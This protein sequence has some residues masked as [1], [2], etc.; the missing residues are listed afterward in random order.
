MFELIH[1]SR[2]VVF[3]CARFYYLIGH[4][5]NAQ[6]SSIFASKLARFLQGAHPY[7]EAYRQKFYIAH[8][9]HYDYLYEMG[10]L[11]RSP[12]T[13]VVVLNAAKL[14]DTRPLSRN[15][16]TDAAINAYKTA[17]DRFEMFGDKTAYYIKSRILELH[18][19]MDNIDFDE[20]IINIKKYEN[21]VSSSLLADLAPYPHVYRFKLYIRMASD[22]MQKSLSSEAA[23]RNHAAAWRNAEA[24]LQEAKMKFE[25]VGNRYG[26]TMCNLF[27]AVMMLF[28]AERQPEARARL[29]DIKAE[30]GRM[31]YCR[32]EELAEFLESPQLM[33]MDLYDLIM[34]FPFVH[35]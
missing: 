14:N 27:S 17:A 23:E 25:I 13:D 32:I 30:A 35:Q 26:T 5:D 33:P 28:E 9:L 4:R 3:D 1:I 11:K 12:S 21:F 20:E 24:S 19:T 6:I 16:I 8:S 31:K 10:A 18:L 2:R 34:F 15:D 29:S 7:Y 22:L